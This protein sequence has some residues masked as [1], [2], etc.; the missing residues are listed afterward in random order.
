[1]AKAS[2]LGIFLRLFTLLM[3]ALAL[4]ALIW[5]RQVRKTFALESLNV[6]VYWD[7]AC[8][9]SVDFVD[10][11]KLK[12]GSSNNVTVFV[13]NEEF[14]KPCV[15]HLGASD[16]SPAKAADYIWLSW[17]YDGKP[18]GVQEVVMAT[19][20]LE[21]SE[22]IQVI[23]D[24]DFNI[25]IFGMEYLPGDLNLD[26]SIDIYDVVEL[27]TAYGSTPS[28]PNW[29]PRA[30]FNSDDL[31]NIHDVTFLATIVGISE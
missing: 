1:L 3:L 6:G 24:F 21:V 12:P 8:R 27:G 13:C 10:W 16:W 26:G 9:W 19:L 23:T 28:D 2:K 25:I 7:S 20:T 11:G 29:N 14:E 17:D 4:G 15:L 31:V 5:P 22:S 18:V 30:D